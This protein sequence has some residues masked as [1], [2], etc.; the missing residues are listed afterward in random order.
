MLLIACLGA[1]V[2]AQAHPAW[3][4]SVFL[5]PARESLRYRFDNPSSFDTE[6]LVPHYFEQTYDTDNVWLG[7]RIAY[8]LFRRTAETRLAVTPQ[9]TRRA[10]DFDTFFQPDGNVVVSGTTGNASL[11]SWQIMQRM[12]ADRLRGADVGVTLTYRRDTARYHEGI[13]IVTTTR[14]PSETRR[15]VTTREFVTSHL[16]EAGAFGARS[17]ASLSAA[18]DVVAVGVGRLAIELPDKYP[19]RTVVASGRYSSATVEG[20]YTRR[21]GPTVARAGIRARASVPWRRSSAMYLRGLSFFVMLGT[22]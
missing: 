15:L 2:I 9:A 10:D 19:G 5:E 16:F 13:G 11:R 4:A 17:W 20:A 3:T 8:P 21:I 12:T 6:P 22:D 14:P 1:L 18:M 7:G